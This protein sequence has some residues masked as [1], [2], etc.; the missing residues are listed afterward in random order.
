MTTYQHYV[1]AYLRED[2]TPYYIGKGKGDRAFKKHGN[3]P[4]PK[5]RS[6]IVFLETRLTDIGALALER[7]YIRWYGRKD[8]GT[9]IL[10]NL[11]DGGDGAAGVQ[12]P[13]ETKRKY[14]VNTS[15]NNKKRV[16]NKTHIFC[17][18]EFQ[19]KNSLRRKVKALANPERDLAIKE[20]QRKKAFERVDA[21]TNPFS[22][23]GLLRKLFAEGRHPSQ[24]IH[25]C[26][27]CN[28]TGKGGPM[29][30]WHFDRCKEKIFL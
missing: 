23:P 12:R 7:R 11:T 19:R 18:S 26:P 13:D 10:R 15:R 8:N 3:L 27:H 28:K 22:G 30:R 14:S 1:Y 16:A 25:V 17:D 4:V 29:K 20:K 24:T 9:G 21:G 5:N 2:G 6:R